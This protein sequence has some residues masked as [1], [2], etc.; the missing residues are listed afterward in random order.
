MRRRGGRR[1]SGGRAP[2]AAEAL[3]RIAALYRI[4]AEI[5]G[6]SADERRAVRQ[7]RSRPLVAALEEVSPNVGDGRGQAA[8][9]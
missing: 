7:E 4:E 8:A 9:A 6:R 3:S 5:R 2:I 1:D